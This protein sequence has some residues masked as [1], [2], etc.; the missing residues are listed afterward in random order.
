MWQSPGLYH[1]AS[2]TGW[3]PYT[4]GQAGENVSRVVDMGRPGLEACVQDSW[5]YVG[6]ISG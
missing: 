6:E 5:A 3:P 1:W 2:T 4:D